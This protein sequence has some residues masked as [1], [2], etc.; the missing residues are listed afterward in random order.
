MK[1]IFV[2]FPPRQLGAR[3]ARKF[4]EMGYGIFLFLLQDED[5]NFFSHLRVPNRQNIIPIKVFTPLA[6]FWEGVDPALKNAILHARAVI[7]FIGADFSK[8]KVTGHGEDWN[9]DVSDPTQVRFSFLE[10]F[11]S[12]AEI[13]ERS[14][15]FNLGTGR[16]VKN[17]TGEIF[18]NTKYGMT[19]FAKA[20]ELTP[21]LRNL[22]II[23]VCLTYLSRDRTGSG[24]SHCTH[25]ITEELV[26]GGKR[27]TSEREIPDFLLN[28]IEELW[29]KKS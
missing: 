25:C 20:F 13:K 19:G 18:C 8:L 15:W 27:L 12:N 28:R 22:E 4:S 24:S 10:I 3:I 14:L 16:H 7:N 23:S 5:E 2:F 11:L 29:M 9:I 26:D 21:R 1:A 17:S 6:R